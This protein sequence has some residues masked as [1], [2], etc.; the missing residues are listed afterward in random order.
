MRIGR[1]LPR[2]AGV[3]ALLSAPA[4]AGGEGWLQDFEAAKSKAKAEGKDLLIDFTGSDWCIWCKRLDQEVFA[5]DAFKSKIHDDYVLVMLDYPQDQSKV[6]DEIRTQNERLQ[7]EYAVQGYPT[8]F[9]TDA[10]GR[11]YAQT[12]YQR[13]GPEK[14]LE[15]IAEFRTK[16]KERAELLAKAGTA[17]GIDKAKLLDEALSSLEDGV[18]LKFYGNEV[19]EIL[20]LDKDNAAGLK[21]KYET[22]KISQDLENTIRERMGKRELAELVADM[23]Q[24]IAKLQGKDKVLQKAMFFKAI[25]MLEQGQLKEAV[26]VLEAAEELKGDP[27]LTAQIAMVIRQVEA[28]LEEPDEPEEGEEGG[29]EDEGGG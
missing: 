24:A 23:D 11:P 27:Q 29:A 15:H 5:T 17:E 16:K 13:G 1:A 25:G 12:G 21:D 3:L 14:Y 20:A 9:L 22:L 4:L 18:V 10:D 8:I 7:Q 28:Q 6:T 19:G 26:P 2:I